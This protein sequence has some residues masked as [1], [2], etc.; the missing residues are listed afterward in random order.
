MAADISNNAV[1]VLL[2]LVIV[3]A[4]LGTWAFLTAFQPVSQAAPQASNAN[5]HLSIYHQPAPEQSSSQAS[6]ALKIAT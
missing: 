1:A 4:A 2:V 5:V 6:V 3:V